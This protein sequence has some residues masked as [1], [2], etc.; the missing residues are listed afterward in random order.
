MF[1]PIHATVIYC[2]LIGAVF[3]ALWFYFDRRD[4]AHFETVLRR[5]AFHCIRCD[6]IYSET[7]GAGLSRCPKCGHENSRLRF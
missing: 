3:S 2:V 4:R 6:Q 5:S 1:E 7:A